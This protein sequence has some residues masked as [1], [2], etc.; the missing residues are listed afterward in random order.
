MTM[1]I[2]AVVAYFT[3]LFGSVKTLPQS[4]A[5]MG[6]DADEVGIAFE[7]L[8]PL[9]VVRLVT[10]PAEQD[11]VR[12]TGKSYIDIRDGR[13][14]TLE[15]GVWLGVF[16]GGNQPFLRP[17]TLIINE[18]ADDMYFCDRYMRYYKVNLTTA[19]TVQ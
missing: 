10:S 12:A 19:N 5:L 2:P 9:T 16:Y 8:N 7:R 3:K 14:Y 11:S 6:V 4:G 17:A 18:V 13:L 15:G 1:L